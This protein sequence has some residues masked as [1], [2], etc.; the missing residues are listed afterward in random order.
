MDT[1]SFHAAGS[2][3]GHAAEAGRDGRAVAAA[4]PSESGG[5]CL[6]AAL[7][8]MG[9]RR[10]SAAPGRRRPFSQAGEAALGDA[11]LR[12]GATGKRGG[13]REAGP[14]PRDAAS[15]SA[16]CGPLQGFVARPP[17]YSLSLR[18]KPQSVQI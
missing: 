5:R 18:K 16:T 11:M 13:G 14:A 12:R 3:R 1:A 17:F 10:K 4:A 15:H 8:E 9:R 2:R 7:Q 6:R